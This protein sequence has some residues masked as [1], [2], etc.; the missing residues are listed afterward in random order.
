M[1]HPVRQTLWS[2]N[3]KNDDFDQIDFYACPGETI[4]ITVRKNQYGKYECFYNNGSSK[5]VERWLKAD[6]IPAY[7][8]TQ[9]YT[10]RGNFE[11]EIK[12]AVAEKVSKLEMPAVFM[13]SDKMLLTSSGKPD[14][15]KIKEKIVHFVLKK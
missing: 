6:L 15:Q 8:G 2:P 14:K 12:K 7:W 4:D 1:H 9:L 3:N 13:F 10:F 5:Q 11:E